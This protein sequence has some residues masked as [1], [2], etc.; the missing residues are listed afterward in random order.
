MNLNSFRINLIG[1]GMTGSIKPW[2]PRVRR[3]LDVIA[4]TFAILAGW[5]RAVGV[6]LCEGFKFKS[7]D[8]LFRVFLVAEGLPSEIYTDDG[9]MVLASEAWVRD[10]LGNDDGEQSRGLEPQLDSKRSTYLPETP[11]WGGTL[12]MTTRGIK[13]TLLRT[14]GDCLLTHG[15]YRQPLN[16]T[17]ASIESSPLFELMWSG[18]RSTTRLSRQKWSSLSRNCKAG[19]RI[20]RWA[21]PNGTPGNFRSDELLLEQCFH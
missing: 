15:E 20:P 3:R 16:E 6:Q 21:V 1:F 12:Q 9:G 19:S 4:G 18:C 10:L 5:V 7:F 2:L 14:V 17:A 8:P 11:Y 13:R